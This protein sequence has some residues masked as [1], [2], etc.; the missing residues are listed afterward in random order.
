[1]SHPWA[2][3]SLTPEQEDALRR[4]DTILARGESARPICLL[5]ATGSGKTTLMRYWLA[6]N[7]DAPEDRLLSVNRIVL[8]ALKSEGSLDEFAE[9]RS[10][11]RIFG[12][13]AVE[14]ALERRFDGTN[15]LVLDGLEL[16]LAYDVPVVEIARAHT[17][18]QKIAILC[19]PSGIAEFPVTLREIECHVVRM[20]SRA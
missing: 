14:D 4:L 19:M 1:M 8:N 11:T 5:G 10:K 3:V 18:R 7:F 16:A 6:T 15:A 9:H 12:R 17:R 13:I 2:T 20:G